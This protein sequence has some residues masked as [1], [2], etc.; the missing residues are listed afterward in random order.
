MSADYPVVATS[1]GPIA[2]PQG[3]RPA[4][5]APEPPEE[6]SEGPPEVARML[7]AIARYKWLTLGLAILGGI[8]GFIA[9]RFV[10]PTYE[11]RAKVWIQSPKPT[12]GPQMTGPIRA[13]EL[14]AQTSWPELF[15]SF[16]IMDS[17]VAKRGLAA[18]PAD[19]KDRPVFMRFATSE[20]PRTGAY[21]LR[22]DAKGQHFTL[23]QKT[24]G[25]VVDT[26]TVG[27]SI[28]RSVGFR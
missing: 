3:L 13:E 24:D 10:S 2:G 19:P 26:G 5:W 14:V 11:A 22:V 28:G 1:A 8:G 18:T 27:D 20:R 9:T 6:S 15:Q 16:A 25:A 17:V 7:G 23:S 21:D 4:P 12:T